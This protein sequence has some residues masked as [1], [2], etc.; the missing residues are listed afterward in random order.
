MDKRCEDCYFH[1]AKDCAGEEN[2]DDLDCWQSVE[3]MNEILQSFSL[4]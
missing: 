4:E 3:D 1:L 2:I